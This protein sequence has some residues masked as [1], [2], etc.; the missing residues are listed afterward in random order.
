MKALIG[1]L[2]IAILCYIIFKLDFLR[3]ILFN[4][5]ELLLAIIGCNLMIGSYKGYRLN[6]VLR[7]REF[8]GIN[9]NV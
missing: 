5:P 4:N 8:E 1:T 3:Q 6:E 2:T 7:F 9:E